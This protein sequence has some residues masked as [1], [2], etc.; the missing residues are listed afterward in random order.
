MFAHE[1][2][3]AIQQ[4]LLKKRRM[5]V[6]ALQRELRVSSATL[7]RDLSELESENLVVRVHGG[8]VHPAT[9][10]GEP[11]FAQKGTQAI[12]AK[13]AIAR[14]T[15]EL[16]PDGATLF[17]DSGTTCLEVARLLLVRRDL[18]II[19]NSIPLLHAATADH[20]ATVIGLGGELRAVSG[21]LT[22]SLALSWLASLQADIAVV[23]ASGLSLE[24]GVSTT[25]LAEAAMKQQFLARS[26]KRIL[27]ADGSKWNAPS[28]A[29]F[30]EWNSFNTWVTDFSLSARERST[31]ASQK[32]HITQAKNE[33][34]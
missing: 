2:H 20:A 1:R 25:E 30:A 33:A 28:T 19:T 29:K 21:A 32:L 27:V 34:Q 22:G 10:R 9:L 12:A 5:S 15:A 31:L 7:R 24:D 23:A 8:V 18:T 14:A 17:I 3:Q 11:T 26:K 4:L 13:R 6:A 16:I